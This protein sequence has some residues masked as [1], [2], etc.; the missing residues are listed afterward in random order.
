[1]FNSLLQCEFKRILEA[2]HL[3]ILG[4]AKFYIYDFISNY[5]RAGKAG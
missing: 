4:G 3:S 1:L 2:L 5:E